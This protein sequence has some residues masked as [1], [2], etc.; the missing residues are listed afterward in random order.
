MIGNVRLVCFY[1]PESVGKS[2]MAERMAEKY[3]TAFVPEVARELITS[4]DFS[5]DD[6]IRIGHAQFDRI[7]EKVKTANKLL[8]CDTDA[9]TTQIYSRHYLNVVPEILEKLEKA[10]HYDLYFLFD[11]DVPWIPDGLRDLPHIRQQMF[12]VFRNELEK[13]KI[14]YVLVNGGWEQRERIVVEAIENL[15]SH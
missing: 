2:S 1:G 14:P 13:R 3:K 6:I 7:N 12:T 8:F 11:I 10:V 5:V 9:I 15:L 4:N